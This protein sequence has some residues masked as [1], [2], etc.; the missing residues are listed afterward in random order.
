MASSRS[1]S[2]RR[3]ELQE[4][5]EEEDQPDFGSP[6][7]ISDV[8]APQEGQEEEPQPCP[9]PD[10]VSDIEDELDV[11][12]VFKAIPV[13]K[14]AANEKEE[15]LCTCHQRAK[16]QIFPERP[17]LIHLCQQP[18]HLWCERPE[19]FRSD[20]L[21]KLAICQG[22]RDQGC[23]G[24]EALVLPDEE[25]LVYGMA[26]FPLVSLQAAL[27]SAGVEMCYM[28]H[29]GYQLEVD[30]LNM[31]GSK[32]L[33]GLASQLTALDLTWTPHFQELPLAGINIGDTSGVTKAFVGPD[34][35]YFKIRVHPLLPTFQYQSPPWVHGTL[36]IKEQRAAIPSPLRG[37]DKGK[38]FTIYPAYHKLIKNQK[39]A[40]SFSWPGTHS[41]IN[42]QIETMRRLIA[43]LQSQDNASFT[44]LRV[45]AR[46]RS[47]DKQAAQTPVE[48]AKAAQFLL[49]AFK[50]LVELG[51]IRIFEVNIEEWKAKLGSLWAVFKDLPQE[52]PGFKARQA[53]WVQLLGTLGHVSGQYER[54]L[55]DQIRAGQELAP[56]P[57]EPAEAPL[58]EAPL[59]LE[60]APEEQ[61]PPPPLGPGD[62][63][64]PVLPNPT[65]YDHIT[66]DCISTRGKEI[67]GFLPQKKCKGKERPYC[68]FYINGWGPPTKLKRSPGFKSMAALAEAL[69]EWE[70]K[71]GPE[72]SH[73]IKL[74]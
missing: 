61:A 11:D 68:C 55:L 19:R 51:I 40:T 41:T 42:R 38:I 53:L 8:E 71:G 44:G 54:N 34:F 37:N 29:F 57:E 39:G 18:F 16:A 45:E 14:L 66:E 74:D 62:G 6:D 27:E 46:V 10:E 21:A 30:G 28:G 48:A 49:K 36:E 47:T 32:W 50:I 58:E 35:P 23:F 59:A 63:Q 12:M 24:I 69:A 65:H 13:D 7:D 26:K 15:L 60:E 73:R 4:E 1:R 5:H 31:L 56:E 33:D 3:E 67:L 22:L 17:H 52:G 43:S 64:E 9:D 2:P 25:S 70:A 72:I 20:Y